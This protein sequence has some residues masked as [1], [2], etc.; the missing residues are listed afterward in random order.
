ML[1][2]LFVMVLS[3]GIHS[4]R[5]ISRSTFAGLCDRSFLPPPGAITMPEQTLKPQESAQLKEEAKVSVSEQENDLH[6]PVNQHDKHT[7]VY[8]FFSNY[9]RR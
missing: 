4:P 7:P 9:N 6:K 3:I 8:S 1:Q 5:L 2:Q